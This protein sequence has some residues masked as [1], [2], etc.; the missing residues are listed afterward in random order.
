LL[1][2]TD[3]SAE[4]WTNFYKEWKTAR[5]KSNDRDR[6]LTARIDEHI[7]KLAMLYSA[8]EK[9]TV[10]SKGALTVAI[11]LG[12][13]L[14][15]VSLRAFSEVG[16]DSFSR[17]EKVV[18]DVVK[19]QPNGRMYR[20]YLQQWVH[21]KGINGEILTRIVNTLVRNGHLKEGVDKT[22]S[23]HERPWVEYVPLASPYG[24]T[25]NI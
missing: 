4:L 1:Q 9:R 18:L 7:L 12:K 23:G 19:S 17:G 8:I 22:S 21:K 2:F 5:Q 20:R 10:I 15:D 14:E 24:L 13:W 6:R 3:D 16:K 25:V 11:E